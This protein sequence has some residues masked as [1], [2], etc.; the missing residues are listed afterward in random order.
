MDPGQDDNADNNKRM[1]RKV[2]RSSSRGTKTTDKHF[3]TEI[4]RAHV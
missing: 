4:G 2:I 1:Q 3:P